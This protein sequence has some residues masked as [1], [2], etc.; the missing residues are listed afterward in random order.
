M[1]VSGGRVLCVV[2]LGETFRTARE[3]AYEAVNQV[4]FAGAQWRRDIG[5]RALSREETKH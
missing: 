2:G 5:Y 4:H 3:T 1:T